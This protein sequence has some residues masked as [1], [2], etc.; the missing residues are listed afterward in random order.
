MV[1]YISSGHTPYKHDLK[2][3][4]VKF[5][6]VECVGN[7]SLNESKLKRITRK[8]YDEEFLKNKVIK[9]SIVCTIKRRICQCFPFIDEPKEPLAMNQDVAF[10]V[11]KKSV[12]AAYLATYFNC[13]IGQSF[14]NRQQ[15]EQ[16]NPYL[17][18][19]N[20]SSLPVYV[21]D[22]DFQLK[23]EEILINAHA[24]SEESKALYAEAENLLLDELGLR[25]W[26]PSDDSISVKSFAES[27]ADTGRLDAEYYQP[28]YDEL[29]T[30][31]KNNSVGVV[32]S[33]NEISEPLR[34]GSSAKLDY[35]E[36]GVP[37]L[38]IADI[39]NHR[40]DAEKI[41]YILGEAASDEVFA[42]VETNDVLVSRSGTLGLSVSIPKH[43]SG[44]IFGSYFIR[45]RPDNDLI[46]SDYLALYLNSKVGAL[47]VEQISTG[48]IQTNLTVP[49]IEALKIVV[50]SKER[51]RHFADAVKKSFSAQDESK[52][53]LEIAKRAVEV[54]IE[55]SEAAAMN[56]IDWELEINQ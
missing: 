31:I 29:M 32:K 2:E 53:L 45:V 24:K 14:A 4:E 54:A 34:Y 27:F 7:L 22:Y 8:Q 43:L 39:T 42:S 18:V 49:V 38:R 5:I 41:K 3:G 51:Q 20:L 30:L 25:D 26:S 48:G 16:M 12:N 55:D 37:F 33:I 1:T 17:S 28:K 50:P 10:F 21:A 36:S 40:F 23:I 56:W 15:T 13:E 44:A 35:I 11:P 46:D 47:Q 6:T 52:Q 19:E 9:G